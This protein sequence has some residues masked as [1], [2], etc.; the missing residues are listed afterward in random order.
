MVHLQDLQDYESL[1]RDAWGIPS[2][3]PTT[4]NK[5]QRILGDG[6]GLQSGSASLDLVLVPGVAFGLDDN[7]SIRRLGHGK[8]FYD[9]F[10]NR[11]I[12]RQTTEHERARP[13]LLYG[14]ALTEQVIPAGEGEPIPV[15]PFDRSLH[16]LLLGNGDIRESSDGAKLP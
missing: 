1:K 11:Y 9:F 10:I 13:P 14:L 8:G 12:S 2:V 4:V 15:G 5:R 7:G 16:G 3:D 6:Q